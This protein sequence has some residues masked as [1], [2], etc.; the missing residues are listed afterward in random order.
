MSGKLINVLFEA[1]IQ[2][3]RDDANT[4]SEIKKYESIIG[5]Y[6]NIEDFEI[7]K[8]IMGMEPMFNPFLSTWRIHPLVDR[9]CA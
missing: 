7:S 3:L 4:R 5:K 9:L 8:S 2:V 6:I 1:I